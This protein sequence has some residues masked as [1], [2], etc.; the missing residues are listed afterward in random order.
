VKN[1]Q[2][3]IASAVNIAIRKLSQI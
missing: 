1:Y 3:I 2:I